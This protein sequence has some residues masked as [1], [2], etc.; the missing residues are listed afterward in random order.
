MTKGRALHIHN[1]KDV[2]MHALSALSIDEVIIAKGKTKPVE[3]QIIMSKTAGMY[4]I[5]E[6]LTPKI[7]AG[8]ISQYIEVTIPLLENQKADTHSSPE[9]S[10]EIGDL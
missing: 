6:I 10:G 8:C 4:Q 2:T 1:Q 7:M 5:Q 3:I 9:I